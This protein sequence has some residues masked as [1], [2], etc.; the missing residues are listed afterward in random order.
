MVAQLKDEAKRLNV[1]AYQGQKDVLDI[2]INIERRTF[3]KGDSWASKASP[4][5]LQRYETKS[6]ERKWGHLM[7]LLTGRRP[8][9]SS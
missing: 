9:L 7:S 1:T 6:I 3:S 8:Q 4:R 2:I 5:L